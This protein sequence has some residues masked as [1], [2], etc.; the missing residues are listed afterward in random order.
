VTILQRWKQT[1]LH[2]KA[3]VLTSVIVAFGTLFYVGVAIFQVCMMRK[4]SDVASF[5]TDKLVHHADRI[6]K[7]LEE[8]GER[9]K[10]A[11][12]ASIEVARAD[13]RAWLGIKAIIL[14]SP[15]SP[16]NPIDISIITL[17]TGKTPALDVNLAETRAGFNESHPERATTNNARL[18]VSPNNDEKFSI[19]AT[20]A[21]NAIIGLRDKRFRFYIRGRI[22]YRDIFGRGHQTT[23]CAYYPTSNNDSFFFNC[24]TGNFM[25]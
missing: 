10:A 16:G 11:L 2:N 19:S 17:N 9:S 6:A 5:Q 1:A 25:N 18:V 15:L 23:F 22:E 8:A 24:P 12:D 3:L 4:A 20:A 7:S 13:Q 21:P 14:A